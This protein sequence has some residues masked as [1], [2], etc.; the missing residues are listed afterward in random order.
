MS[1]D[2]HIWQQSAA[3]QLF[4]NN[5]NQMDGG[6]VEKSENTANRKHHRIMLVSR[7]E[8]TTRRERK[9]TEECV[10]GVARGEAEEEAPTP[11][12]T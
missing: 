5:K 11:H 1:I 6:D 3:F 4:I 12:S 9:E 2:I 10:D 7:Q 8:E